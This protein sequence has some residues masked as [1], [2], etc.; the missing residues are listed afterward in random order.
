MVIDNKQAK[1]SVIILIFTFFNSSLLQPFISIFYMRT[2]DFFSTNSMVHSLSSISETGF[3]IDLNFHS[4][5][6]FPEN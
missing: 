2:E 5:I 6:F 1:K 4:F 3:I